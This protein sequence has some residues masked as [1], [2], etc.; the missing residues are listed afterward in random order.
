MF[1]SNLFLSAARISSTTAS[2]FDLEREL[3]SARA[4][5]CELEE[6]E[7]LTKRILTLPSRTET[8]TQIQRLKEM[9]TNL[10]AEQA[11][12]QS[13]LRVKQL[14]FKDVL[15]SMELMS[16]E[17]SVEE[18]IAKSVADAEAALDRARAVEEAAMREA[19][20]EAKLAQQQESG[21][22]QENEEVEH[23]PERETEGDGEQDTTDQTASGDKDKDE[24]GGDGEDTPRDTSAVPVDDS[25]NLDPVDESLLSS[26]PPPNE[27]N[28]DQQLMREAGESIAS[29]IEEGSIGSIEEESVPMETQ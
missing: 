10:H 11:T 1:S 13:D 6:Y 23:E 26:T 25:T 20:L 7:Q 9:E 15:N 21:G 17:W 27:S 19:A 18:A 2:L 3:E 12:L 24:D 29:P 14:K 16:S 5:R 4:R 28:A 8:K 22:Q